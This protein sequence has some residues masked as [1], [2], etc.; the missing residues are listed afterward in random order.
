MLADVQQLA[1]WLPIGGVTEDTELG[2]VC[3]ETYSHC[4]FFPRNTISSPYFQENCQYTYFSKKK[5]CLNDNKYTSF[6][7]LVMKLSTTMTSLL[8]Q[9]HP[10]YQILRSAFSLDLFLGSGLLW[11]YIA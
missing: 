7:P 6:L 2:F 1:G 4:I 10:G 8:M 3:G 11:L 9:Y 5:H